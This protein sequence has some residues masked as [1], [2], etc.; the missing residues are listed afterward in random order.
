MTVLLRAGPVL[1]ATGTRIDGASTFVTNLCILAAYLLG[2]IGTAGL[3]YS[4]ADRTY[5]LTF[6]GAMNLMFAAGV[7]ASWPI[8]GGLVGVSQAAEL[9]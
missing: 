5:G 8:L 7:T 9:P 6:N 4:I 3:I 2:F 1:A